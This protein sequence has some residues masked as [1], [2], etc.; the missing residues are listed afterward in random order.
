MN[1]INVKFDV[2]PISSSLSLLIRY[3]PRTKCGEDY[4]AAHQIRFLL[5]LSLCIIFPAINKPT[6]LSSSQWNVKKSDAHKLQHIVHS[7][8]L[9]LGQKHRTPEVQEERGTIDKRLQ[10]MSP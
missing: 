5:F 3:I 1:D 8:Y 4:L 7:L 9:F 10:N 6:W 2:A